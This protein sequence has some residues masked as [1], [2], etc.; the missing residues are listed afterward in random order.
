MSWYLDSDEGASSIFGD[1]RLISEASSDEGRDDLTY[2][3]SVP[4]PSLGGGIC[5]I[6]GAIEGGSFDQRPIEARAD[7]LIYTSDVLTESLDVSG[8]VR[9]ELFVSSDVRDTDFTVKLID[10][11]PDGRA[12]NLDETILRARYRDG[13][14]HEVFMEE[15]E[16]Y[17][18]EIGPMVTSNVFLPGH[19]IRLEISSSN[20][21]RFA[22]NLNT[23]GANFN[24]SEYLVAHN[25]VHHSGSHPSRIVLTVVDP[26]GSKAKVD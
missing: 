10:V 24:E 18:I 13:F 6:G 23:G 12:Y 3:P 17:P 4:V 26:E 20:F 21:P 7:V 25:V 5:C 19:R 8:P 2:D 9:V 1:G 16:I 14:D 11:Y 22:R 15:G